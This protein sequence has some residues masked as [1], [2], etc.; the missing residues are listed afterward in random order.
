MLERN[1]N[2]FAV[3]GAFAEADLEARL[4]FVDFTPEDFV[5]I[6]EIK[7]EILDHLD[8]HLVAFFDHLGRFEKARGLIGSVTLLQEATQLKREHL[9]AMVGGDYGMLYVAQQFRLGQIYNRAQLDMGLYMGAFHA[10]IS[11]VAERITARFPNDSAVALAHYRSFKKVAFF[12]LA[13][14]VDGVVADREQTIRRQQEAIRELS[15]PT[16][17]VRE[18]LLILPIIGLLDSHRAKQLT[19]TLLHA[20]RTH[21]AKVVVVDMTGVSTVDSK[22]ANHLIQTVEAARLMGATAIVTGL[23][24]DVAQSLVTLGVDLSR[25]NTM[26]DLQGG[27]EKAEQLLG[28]AERSTERSGH[29]AG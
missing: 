28:Y 2:E 4:R 9:I 12:D 27:I 29:L 5:R 13:I 11:G 22:V 14:I 10:L 7:D 17:Q 19:D 24:A 26:G 25:L 6:T 23:S 18:R 16:L 20:I 15:T 1:K 3:V 21:R 8:E